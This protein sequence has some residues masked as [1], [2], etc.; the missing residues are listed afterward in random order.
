MAFGPHELRILADEPAF[1][2]AEGRFVAGIPGPPP[3]MHDWDEGFYVISGELGIE[4]G[5]DH[6]ILGPG[7]FALA[8]GG[9]AHTFSVRGPGDAIFLAT[10]S[11]SDGLAYIR[12]MAALFGEGGRPG[13]GRL[14]DLYERYGVKLVEA[15]QS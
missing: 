11:S 8:R 12:E 7:D 2:F 15:P 4:V 10:F 14:F 6:L 9:Q 1:G 5:D 3:H 13:D